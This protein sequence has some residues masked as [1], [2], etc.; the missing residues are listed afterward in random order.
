MKRLFKRKPSKNEL[1][2]LESGLHIEN[3]IRVSYNNKNNVNNIVFRLLITMLGLFGTIFSFISI[4]S[5]EVN[6]LHIA[7]S[8]LLFFGMF[9][10]ITLL[11]DK[12]M[13]SIFPLLLIFLYLFND[14]LSEFIIGFKVVAN[15]ISITIYTSGVWSKYYELPS[16]LDESSYATLFLIFCIFI[17]TILI[18]LFTIKIHSCV[19]GFALT[20][21]FI[22]CGLYFGAVPNYVSFFMVVC[23]WIAL[24]SMALS[25]CKKTTKNKSAGF[26]RVGNSFYAKS[27]GNFRISEKI[28]ISSVIMCIVC[29]LLSAGI[30][31][32]IGYERSEKIDTIRNDVKDSINNFSL[33]DAS[34]SL[35]RLG[36]MLSSGSN[37]SF[38]GTLGQRDNIEFSGEEK[39]LLQ[40]TIKPSN[41]IYLKSYVGSV[42]TGQSWDKLSKGDYESDVFN[43]FKSNN[44]YPQ[45]VPY[46]QLSNFE[47]FNITITSANKSSKSTF[48]PYY[49]NVDDTYSFVYDTTVKAKN[50]KEYSFEVIDVSLDDVLNSEVLSIDGFDNDSYKSFVD[51][52]YLQIEDNQSMDEVRSIFEEYLKEYNLDFETFKSS[53]DI[54]TKLDYIKEFLCSNYEYTLSPGKTPIG[55]DYVLYFLTN[56]NKGYCSHFASAG[57]LFCRMLGI[58]AR[59]VEGYYVSKDSFSDDTFDGSLYN[60]SVK[61]NVAHAWTEIYIDNI[62]WIDVE[63]TPGFNGNPTTVDFSSENNPNVSQEDLPTTQSIEDVTQPMDTQ[64]APV[65]DVSQDVTTESESDVTT[66]TSEDVQHEPILTPQTIKKIK[67]FIV[68]IL[69]IALLVAIVILRRKTIVG[70]RNDSISSKNCKESILESYRYIVLLLKHIGFKRNDTTPY[71]Q[72]AKD[73]SSKLEYVKNFDVIMNIVLKSELSNLE[74]SDDEKQIVNTFAIDLAN[75]IFEKG[76]KLDRFIMKYI[77]CLI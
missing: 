34:Y 64:V 56:S 18:C 27:D 45:S 25:G 63:F 11:P 2:S 61:D 10:T 73:V 28:G 47:N 53:A 57:T 1:S 23:Y 44:L 50:T 41:D 37:G 9:A 51:S 43:A 70:R 66:S 30:V 16:N 35:S 77:F 54:Y 75:T 3:S 14:Y 29:V 8:T 12:F 4:F 17:L 76:S 36:N 38:N 74:I 6:T 72:F 7:V 65:T 49:S 5:I 13:I 71:M 31:S 58:P 67:N 24:L 33:E 60:V 40:S 62:G 26:V 22:E 52:Y 55:E 21:P 20:F 48:V 59:Y 19:M 46:L 68:I 69:S 32:A 39:L 42:Y 15:Y